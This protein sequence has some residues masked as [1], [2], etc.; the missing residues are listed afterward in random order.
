MFCFCVF[1]TIRNLSIFKYVPLYN[2]YMS[3]KVSAPPPLLNQKTPFLPF[4][5]CKQ[6]KELTNCKNYYKL[7]GKTIT[8][9]QIL[10]LVVS[11]LLCC[12]STTRKSPYIPG[13]RAIHQCKGEPLACSSV[14][15]PG[16]LMLYTSKEQ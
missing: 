13:I 11:V 8:K 12:V 7:K 1:I 2:I 16:T 3:N 9:K 6:L 5:G 14:P 15:F 4:Q 10:A